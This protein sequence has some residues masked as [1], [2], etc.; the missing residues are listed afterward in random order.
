MRYNRV[1]EGT[2]NV[3]SRVQGQIAPYRSAR[4]ARDFITRDPTK[5]GKVVQYNQIERAWY[6]RVD[7]HDVYCIIWLTNP[8]AL[9]H[10]YFFIAKPAVR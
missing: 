10:F 2:S 9:T 3:R 5:A 6:P 1:K 7:T 8:I 4:G